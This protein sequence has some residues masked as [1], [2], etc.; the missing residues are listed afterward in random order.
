MKSLILIALLATVCLIVFVAGWRSQ[1]PAPPAVQGSL[2]VIQSYTMP[3][4]AGGV[5]SGFGF[6]NGIL[7]SRG[8]PNN[9]AN[10][11]MFS[12]DLG[13]HWQFVKV[14]RSGRKDVPEGLG[15][16]GGFEF[17][18]PEN[19]W[20]YDI[21]SLIRTSDGGRSWQNLDDV[22]KMFKLTEIRSVH[23]VDKDTGFLGASASHIIDKGLGTS[24]FAIVILCTNDGGDN[25]RVC[26][27]EEGVGD[28]RS[29]V[30]DGKRVAALSDMGKILYTDDLGKT[31]ASSDLKRDVSAL[32]PDLNGRFWLTRRDG[33]LES[34][35]DLINWTGSQVDGKPVTKK[36]ETIAFSPTGNGFGL[37]G[38]PDGY[39]LATRNF[40]ATW[41][42]VDLKQ[43]NGDIW[44]IRVDG[45]K[46]AMLVNGRS[47]I[48]LR[49]D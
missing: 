46:A 43:V 24:H 39:L 36:L 4:A 29:I 8:S 14:P 41:T 37:A 49:L 6:A 25:W 19:G 2:S 3:T 13:T 38:G 47:I 40:G 17:V 15:G 28:V 21:R 20:A 18:D 22:L 12:A 23:F 9:K 35:T 45:T 32:V 27:K 7:W 11:L 33:G 44:K 30:S 26:K 10:E 34:S 5:T 16:D 1:S 31:W 48:T 42:Q